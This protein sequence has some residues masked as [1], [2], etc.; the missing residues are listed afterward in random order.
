MAKDSK[1]PKS[2]KVEIDFLKKIAEQTDTNSKSIEKLFDRLDHLP[3]S[4][5]EPLRETIRNP[6]T[7]PTDIIHA[8]D[9]SD[10]TKDFE[11]KYNISIKRMDLNPKDMINGATQ[12]LV[13]ACVKELEDVLKRHYVERFECNYKLK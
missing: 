6:F 7:S 12:A 13:D 3:I 10:T 11:L 1:K 5:P 4:V 2:V 8:K 9:T